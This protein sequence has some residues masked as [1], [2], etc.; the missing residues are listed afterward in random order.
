VTFL[1]N[2]MFS[3]LRFFMAFGYCGLGGRGLKGLGLALEKPCI[4]GNRVNISMGSGCRILGRVV[5][6]FESGG[7]LSIGKDV[8]IEDGAYFN[9]HGGEIVIGNGCFIGRGAVIQGMGGVH[10]GANTL[11]GPY[12][13]IYSSNHPVHA[14]GAPRKDLPENPSPVV[15]GDNCWMCASS[16]VVAGTTVSS[17]DVILPG[18]VRRPV[19]MRD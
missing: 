15:L 6:A 12:S 10:L 7:T 14:D 18:E 13:Q 2:K 11:L 4:R 9:P 8:V 16:M 5:F 17:N 19:K 3:A 1:I